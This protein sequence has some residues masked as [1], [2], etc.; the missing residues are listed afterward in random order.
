[1]C[2]VCVVLCVVLCVV[3]LFAAPGALANNRYNWC[4]M[5]AAGYCGEECEVTASAP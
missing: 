5:D 1:M 4:D 3:F 2:Y